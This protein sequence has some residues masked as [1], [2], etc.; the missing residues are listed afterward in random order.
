MRDKSS[1]DAA[2]HDFGLAGVS[3]GIRK[4]RETIRKLAN[5]Q[6][7]VL[8]TGESGV[9]KELVAHAVHRTSALADQVFLP[10]DSASLVGSLMESELFGYQ[11]GA[12]TGADDSKLGLVRAAHGGTL[13]LDE[14]GELPSDVQAKLLRLLQEGEMRPIGGV[15]PVK[16]KVRILAATNRDLEAEVRPATFAR[17][18]TTGSTS[19]HSRA[20]AARRR[21]DI[22]L[23]VQ[24]FVERHAVHQVIVS[25]EVMEIFQAYDWPGNVRELENTVRCLVALKSNPGVAIDDL[26]APLLNVAEGRRPHGDEVLPLA[27]MERRHILN[28][29]DLTKGD[30]TA[31][32]L[33]LGMGRTTLYRRLKDYRHAAALDEEDDGHDELSDRSAV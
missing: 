13:F 33:M 18:C 23:L 25:D 15:Q 19:S 11:K 22:P 32:A 26:P 24:H 9:G 6:S 30:V 2:A 29:M 16:V 4:V 21:D 27:E 17:I 8:I 28:V 10:V 1:E 31:A 3:D 7:P 12:F 20:A 5:D 14:I